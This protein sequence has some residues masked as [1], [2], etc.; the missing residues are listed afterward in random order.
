MPDIF[1][2]W[3]RESMDMPEIST[4]HKD[5]D[6]DDPAERSCPGETIRLTGFRFR[7]QFQ[8]HLPVFSVQLA[9]N[10]P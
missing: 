1:R 8:K 9:V 10:T 6:S 3:M 5:A 4:L 7:V 2:P